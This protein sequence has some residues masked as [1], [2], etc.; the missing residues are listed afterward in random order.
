VISTP[1]LGKKKNLLNTCSTPATQQGH[2]IDAGTFTLLTS[3]Q[4]GRQRY[5]HFLNLESKVKEINRPK[6]T[7]CELWL[8]IN[9]HHPKMLPIK[10]HW[11]DCEKNT[12]QES[13]GITNSDCRPCMHS[14]VSNI[15][16]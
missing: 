7:V 4:A 15:Q 14:S 5:F 8:N 10:D 11:K 6:V 16:I 3:L 13:S 9:I 12:K 1:K 2:L